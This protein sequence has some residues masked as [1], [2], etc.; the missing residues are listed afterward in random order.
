MKYAFALALLAAIAAQAAA[1]PPLSPQVQLQRQ[2]SKA[3]YDRKVAEMNRQSEAR[4][5][6]MQADNAKTRQKMDE[7]FQR[8]W[9]SRNPSSQLPP[10]DPAAAPPPAEGL[11]AIITATRAATSM[12]QVLPFLPVDRQQSLREQQKA[13]DPKQAASNREW[14]KRNGKLDEE[15]LTFLSNPPFTNFLKWHKG[16]AGDFLDVLAT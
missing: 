12:E 2:K 8:K 6:Q 4:W 3:E 16:I 15:S 7:D 14:H 1:A 11:R 10:F 13:Y 9:E 5:K